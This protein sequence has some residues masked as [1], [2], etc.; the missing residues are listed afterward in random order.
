MDTTVWANALEKIKPYLFRITTKA[1][2]GTGFQLSHSPQ[3]NLCAVATALQVVSS[4][5]EWGEPMKLNHHSSGETIFL[6]EGDRVMYRLLPRDLAF[7]VFKKKDIPLE[8]G[9]FHLI[10]ERERLREGVQMGWCGFPVVA[11][12]E[13]CFFTGYVSSYLTEEDAYLIDGVTISGVSGGPAFFVQESDRVVL[14]GIAS[15][16]I[17][18]RATGE[19]LPGVS[20]VRSISPYHDRLKKLKSLEKAA[21]EAISFEG[22]EVL[23]ATNTKKRRRKEQK[24]KKRKAD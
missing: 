14:C 10:G 13:L 22:A 3:T 21:E 5:F 12:N 19:A 8:A 2:G 17:P 7:I 6:G 24:R 23:E 18:N 20:V 15:A 1:G 4:A 11:P 9:I 16:Y